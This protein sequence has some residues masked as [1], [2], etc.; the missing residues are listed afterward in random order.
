MVFLFTSSLRHRVGVIGM[1]GHPPFRQRGVGII[2]LELVS[3]VS[4]A[5]PAVG[6]C[7]QR[8][9][10]GSAEVSFPADVVVDGKHPPNDAAVEKGHSQTDSEQ[11]SVVPN[12]ATR[13]KK[14]GQSIDEATGADVVAVDSEAPKHGSTQEKEPQPNAQGNR[15]VEVEQKSIEREEAHRVVPKVPP[16]SM[17]EGVGKDASKSVKRPRMHAVFPPTK[18]Q[19]FIQHKHAP[20]GD[21]ESHREPQRISESH[22]VG[23][24]G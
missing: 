1:R 24:Q 14:S 20:D 8:T 13:E 17:Q 21:Q 4:G 10:D 18:L 16:I 22:A 3:R 11:Q 9:Y 5:L 7:K 23:D 6:D 15:A 19:G 2:F 12:H